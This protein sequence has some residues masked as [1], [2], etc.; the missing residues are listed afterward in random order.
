LLLSTLLCFSLHVPQTTRFSYYTYTPHIEYSPSI[1]CRTP[2]LGIE[3][4]Q[5]LEAT[6]AGTR[7]SQTSAKSPPASGTKTPAKRA[8]AA[9]SGPPRKRGR[10]SK[11][12]LEERAQQ[13]T[14]E[15]MNDE[16]IA[17]ESNG[18]T[19]E[20]VDGNAKNGVQQNTGRQSAKVKKQQTIEEAFDGSEG[21]SENDAQINGDGG[22]KVNGNAKNG[23]RDGKKNAFDEVKADA[24]EVKK[25]AKEEQEKK[26]EAIAHNNNSVIEDEER[27]AAIPSSVLEKGIIYFVFRARVNIDEPE[28]VEDV[29][30]S[31]IILRPLPLGAKLGE[32]PLADT[33]DAR[34]L[35]L[36]KKVLPKSKADRF[37]VFVEDPDGQVPDLRKDFA[38]SE[39]ATQTSGLVWVYSK[40]SKRESSLIFRSTSHVPA[41]TPFACGVYAITSTGRESHLAYHVTYPENMGEVQNELGVR[42]KGSF[43]CSVKN[44]KAPGPSNATL[45]NPADYPEEIQKKFR[46]LRWMPLQPELLNYQ[47]TQ[48]LLIGEGQGDFGH[49]LDEMSKDS[50]DDEKD[51]P[52]EVLEQLEEEVSALSCILWNALEEKLPMKVKDHHRVKHLEE[53]DPV[54]ADLGLSGKEFSKIQTSWL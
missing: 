21:H 13:Q 47:F 44:P 6:M 41:A 31:Y 40:F 17:E 15:D 3:A 35:V 51:A 30:R 28:G 18:Y 45:G 27:E 53:D 46:N 5:L 24:G 29:A 34:L 37:L 54:F 43:I 49:A 50:K 11:K 14:Q 10:P 22:N 39:Y 16:D 20:D 9:S 2:S 23:I 52:E 19:N 32:G 4:N 7:G 38:S 42:E 8:A 25:A 26:T 48:M 12:D 36:P 1:G 33:G